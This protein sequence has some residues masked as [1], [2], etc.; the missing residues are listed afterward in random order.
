MIQTRSAGG[1]VINNGLVLVV[2]QHGR[3]WSLPKGHIEDGEDAVAA[4][5][6]EIYEETGITELKYIGEL[7]TYRRYKIGADG[8][9]DTSELK[10][11]TM[12]LFTTSQTALA[13]VDPENPEAR[14]VAR[15]DVAGLLTHIKDKE[16]FLSIVDCLPDGEGLKSSP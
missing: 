3:S 2:S 15:E 11:I 16:F 13:P 14:W 7:G 9:E 12:F 6:R 10:T 5:R 4:A 1:V 8:S